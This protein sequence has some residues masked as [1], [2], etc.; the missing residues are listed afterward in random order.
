M[1]LSGHARILAAPAMARLIAVLLATGTVVL[2]VPARAA[3]DSSAV[4]LGKWCGS[5]TLDITSLSPPTGSFVPA[6]CG[7]RRRRAPVPIDGGRRFRM[8]AAM[9]SDDPGRSLR[10]W[11]YDQVRWRCPGQAGLALAMALRMDSPFR[12]RRC[13]LWTRRSRM[14][15]ARVGSPMAA[16]QASTGS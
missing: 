16:C 9:D 3:G 6:P 5:G 15:S 8:M 13:A 11:R 14:A 2:S 4:F 1:R 7:F 12:M 10:R